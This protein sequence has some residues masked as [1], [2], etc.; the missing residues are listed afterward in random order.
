MPPA[1]VGLPETSPFPGTGLPL[2]QLTSP[3]AGDT[4]GLFWGHILRAKPLVQGGWAGH[5]AITPFLVLSQ[6]W[7]LLQDEDQ[8]AQIPAPS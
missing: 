2:P 4:M 1:C 6:G 5:T 7:S 3:Q 8:E